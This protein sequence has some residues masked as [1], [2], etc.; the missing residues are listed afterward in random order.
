MQTVKG[1]TKER[2]VGRESRFSLQR[3]ESEGSWTASVDAEVMQQRAWL[4]R[5]ARAGQR[6]RGIILM[7][8]IS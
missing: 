1:F 8:E 5:N 2:A 4:H 3:Q 7:R 6:S